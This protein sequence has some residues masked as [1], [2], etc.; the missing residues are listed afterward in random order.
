MKLLVAITV[1]VALILVMN[2]YDILRDRRQG[3]RPRRTSRH[4]LYRRLWRRNSDLPALPAGSGERPQMNVTYVCFTCRRVRHGGTT[5]GCPKC[6]MKMISIGPTMC[7]PMR[8]MDQS[9]E[10]LERRVVRQIKREART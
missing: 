9:W 8:W 7:V 5:P 3:V 6:A 10:L 2:Y 4:R 1:I